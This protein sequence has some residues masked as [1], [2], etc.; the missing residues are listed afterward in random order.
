MTFTN[1]HK[2]MKVPYVVYADFECML[3]KIDNCIPNNKRSF[4]VETEKH[5]PCGFSYLVERS[6]GLTYGLFT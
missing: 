1:C 5:E 2:Q 3:R 4:T 6:D